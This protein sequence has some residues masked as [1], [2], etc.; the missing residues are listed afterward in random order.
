MCR[1]SSTV[2]MMTNEEGMEHHCK[3]RN[4]IFKVG[5]RLGS[6]RACSLPHPQGIVRARLNCAA[7]SSP[8]AALI[9][10]T[11]DLHSL[12]SAIVSEPM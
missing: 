8:R 2:P 10:S 4:R 7:R 9:G 5:A 1:P 3:V 11:L 6:G 12:V